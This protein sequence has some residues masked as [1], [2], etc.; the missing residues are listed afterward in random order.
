[1]Y[2]IE[3]K[4]EGVTIIE[5]DKID[6]LRWEKKRENLMKREYRFKIKQEWETTKRRNKKL[7]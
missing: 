2:V 6:R 1:M 3:K 5:E 7:K 4:E